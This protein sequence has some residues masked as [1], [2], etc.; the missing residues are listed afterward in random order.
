MSA[1]AVVVNAGDGDTGSVGNSFGSA[2]ARR[3][4]AEGDGMTDAVFA[5]AAAVSDGDAEGSTSVF[6]G[7]E[8]G[9]VVAGVSVDVE[10]ATAPRTGG[11]VGARTPP[12][13][14]WAWRATTKSATATKAAPP[15]T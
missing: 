1:W 3:A 8:A 6:A 9:G 5:W 13:G 12:P 10:A 14:Q 7:T 2:I 4:G 11:V 15:P